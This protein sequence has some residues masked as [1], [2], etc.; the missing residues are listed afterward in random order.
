MNKKIIIVISSIVLF[1]CKTFFACHHTIKKNKPL[2]TLRFILIGNTNP[3]SPF[4]GFTKWLPTVAAEIQK[5]D[6]L[7]IVHTGNMVTG[8]D[9]TSGIRS[10]DMVRQFSIFNKIM[11][12][13]TNIVYTLIGKSDLLHNSKA[14][15]S[16]Q[17]KR[18]INYTINYGTMHIIFFN[19]VSMINH[20]T[21]L[22][23]L[24]KELE[25]SK[26]YDNIIIF[27][28]FPI[29]LPKGWKGTIKANT[30]MH[31]LIKQYKV[32]AVFSGNYGRNF[33][34]QKDTIFYYTLGCGG[35]KKEDK[36]WLYNQFYVVDISPT[37]IKITPKKVNYYAIKK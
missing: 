20:D 8:G 21:N 19:T 14:I 32:R 3:E 23:W 5:E 29:F 18:D 16:S 17:T 15:Y 34:V 30:K 26:H 33:T 36:Y 2:P 24:K 1:S 4:I 6:P 31:N 37:G 22:A 11:Q 25:N 12:T 9:K 28:H 13:K 35:F 10:I 27:T 7:F